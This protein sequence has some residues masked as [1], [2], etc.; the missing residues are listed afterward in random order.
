LSTERI[1]NG[2]GLRAT[3]GA[4][5]GASS[6]PRIDREGKVKMESKYCTG[7]VR[8]QLMLGVSTNRPSSNRKIVTRSE[9]YKQNLNSLLIA[10]KFIS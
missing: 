1:K 7:L 9:E 8:G 10:S 4:Y 2:L 5:D 3:L 6:K